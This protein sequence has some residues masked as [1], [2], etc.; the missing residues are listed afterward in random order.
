MKSLLILLLSKLDKPK[1]PSDS[2]QDITSSP[3]TS[4]A[5]LLWTHSR[6]FTS[7]LN[8]G[9]QNCI[10]C[11]RHC[12]YGYKEFSRGQT[13]PA[14]LLQ[15]WIPAQ[16]G[17]GAAGV[18]PEETPGWNSNAMRKGWENG[19]FSTWKKRVFKATF[20]TEGVKDSAGSHGETT[21]KKLEQPLPEG[22][23]PL[24]GSK[25][26]QPLPEGL[27]PL[28]E[29]KLEQ[30]FQRMWKRFTLD[31]FVE[32]FGEEPCLWRTP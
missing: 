6:T 15:P 11:S 23:T 31:Y 30:P 10:Q 3:S 7:F 8:C 20:P 16:E 13:P 29:S 24:E 28:E 4:F 32:N 5:V 26:E 18:N 14:E 22:L 25:L 27:V 1:I 2:S 9:A 17:P 12:L 21:L 19:D